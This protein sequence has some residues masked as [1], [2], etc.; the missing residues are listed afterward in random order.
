MRSDRGSEYTCSAFLQYLEDREIGQYLT[1]A[2]T[3]EQNGAAERDDRT[4]LEAARSMMFGAN[5]HERF[6]GEAATTA[7]Y[8]INRTATRTLDGVTP[9]EAWHKVRPS[10]SHIRIFGSDAYVHKPS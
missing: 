4:I 9:Y 1:T 8:V 5:F 2:Y 3:P 6:W 7:V 10:L